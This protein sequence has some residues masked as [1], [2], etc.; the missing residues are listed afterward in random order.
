MKKRFNMLL[1][2]VAVLLVFVPAALAETVT[3]GNPALRI[4][5][6]AISSAA[7][8]TITTKL[9]KAL[10]HITWGSPFATVTNGGTSWVGSLG[11]APGATIY[12]T[13][14]ATIPAE[15]KESAYATYA[16][17]TVEYVAP[18]APTSIL[19]TKP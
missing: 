11:V 15:N 6:S 5:E 2:Y 18:K 10:D 1:L 12:V 4:D 9:Y 14:S 8:A 7:Q 13:V 16:T 19:I 17:W 3:W